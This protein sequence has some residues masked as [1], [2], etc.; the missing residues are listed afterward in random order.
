MKINVFKRKNVN[1]TTALKYASKGYYFT[2]TDSNIL[3][4]FQGGKFIL[5]FKS[6]IDI[7]TKSISF[8]EPAY[9][10]IYSKSD[11]TECV[12]HIYKKSYLFNDKI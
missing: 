4:G 1:I 3:F 12:W 11:V 10:P 5:G 9:V 7:N 8:T 6:N 2:R